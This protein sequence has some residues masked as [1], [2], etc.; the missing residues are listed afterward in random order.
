MAVKLRLRRM[1]KKRQPYYKLVAADSRSPRDGKFL[2]AVGIYN[3]MTQPHQLEISEDAA[4]KWL[5]NGAQPTDTVKSLLSQKGIMLKYDLLK[6]GLTPEAI[7]AEV[8]NWQRLKEAAAANKTV[9]K[10]KKKSKGTEG[11]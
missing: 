3:P 7:E 10:A 1:G 4:I 2:E 8:A 5:Q 11:A 6:R 9:K